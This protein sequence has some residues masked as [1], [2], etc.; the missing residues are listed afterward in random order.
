MRYPVIATA[1][2][3]LTGCQDDPT[4]RCTNLQMKVWDENPEKAKADI[5]WKTRAEYEAWS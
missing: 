4:T 2:L 1:L 5:G 3:F